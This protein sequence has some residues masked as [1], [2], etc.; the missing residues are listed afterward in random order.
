AGTG[1]DTTS[2]V[3]DAVRKIKKVKSELRAL[4]GTL[5]E[6]SAREMGQKLKERI[7][8]FERKNDIEEY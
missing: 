2:D 3:D 4:M 1:L 6:D 7:E 5:K 8:E